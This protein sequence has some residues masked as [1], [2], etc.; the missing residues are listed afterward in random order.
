MHALLKKLHPCVLVLTFGHISIGAAAEKAESGK[1]QSAEGVYTS[2]IR[3]GEAGLTKPEVEAYL[4]KY[5]PRY[6]DPRFQEFAKAHKEY[7]AFLAKALSDD[8]DKLLSNRGVTKGSERVITKKA[9]VAV[10]TTA[11][12][13]LKKA[14]PPDYL[15]N[16]TGGI[17]KDSNLSITKSTTIQGD[18]K[19]PA[20]FSWT[21]DKTG[22]FFTADAAITYKWSLLGETGDTGFGVFV[23]PSVEVH[24]SSQAISKRQ[25]DSISAKL[26]I[27]L[28]FTPASLSDR[29]WFIGH[30][31]L[32]S[33]DYERDRK[34]DVQTF[35]VNVLYSPT[36]ARPIKTGE[37]ITFAEFVRALHLGASDRN[38]PQFIWRPYIGFENGY[39]NAS[40]AAPMGALL[41]YGNEHDYSRFVMTLHGD[42][43]M[44][45]SFDIAVDYSHRTF[46]TGG[47][48]SFDYVEVSPILY[49]DG[50]PDDPTSQHFSIGM[51]LKDGKTTPQFKNVKSISAWLGIKF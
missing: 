36:L 28:D 31:F 13:G 22:S 15:S 40:T 30:T 11:A 23:N 46:L 10:A 47:G 24:T 14:P 6:S 18:E 32:I 12:S 43:Y 3:P 20:Q 42:V 49:L 19:R 2:L 27:E 7:R 34:K 4:K 21:H 33:P 45:P 25:Q 16:L 5:D 17:L 35:G 26:P 48:N 51:T 41:A 38:Y 39:L 37:P 8:A 9:F 50:S 1:D 44:T 29:A